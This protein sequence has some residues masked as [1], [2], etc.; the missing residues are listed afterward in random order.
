MTSGL[1]ALFQDD[2]LVYIG[3]SEHIHRRLR[4]HRMDG[5]KVFNRVLFYQLDDPSS[6]L[7]AEGILI[8]THMPTD[9]KA[10]NL[11]MKLGKVWEI[12]WRSRP[13]QSKRSPRK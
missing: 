7:R 3:Q 4:E 11:G 6:R 13:Y 10:L 1:Y 9:N 12:R 2:V 8:L 5:A